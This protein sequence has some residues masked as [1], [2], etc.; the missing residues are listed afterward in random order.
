METLHG[1]ALNIFGTGVII[2]GESAIGKSELGLAL[3]DRGHKFIVDDAIRLTHN[4]NGLQV[5][6]SNGKFILHIR[7]IGFIDVLQ[8]YGVNSVLS[9][10]EIDLNIELTQDDVTTLDQLTQLKTMVTIF[11]VQIPQFTIPVAN[12]RRPLVLLVELVVKYQQ[13]LLRGI[14]SHSEFIQHHDKNLISE[15]K[16]QL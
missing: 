2:T 9:S 8:L 14:D 3:I 4:Q 16:H 12:A 10:G 11:G 13:Q 6:S 1:I 7:G 15:R 5:H